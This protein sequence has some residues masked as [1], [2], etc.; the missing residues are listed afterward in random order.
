MRS[1]DDVMRVRLCGD[2]RLG[3]FLLRL[4]TELDLDLLCH[5]DFTISYIPEQQTKQT[6]YSPPLNLS[7]RCKV[8]SFWIL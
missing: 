5:F 7:T 8:L 2:Q 6:L 3:S 1:D 4:M